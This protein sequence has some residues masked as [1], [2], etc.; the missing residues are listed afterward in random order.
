MEEGINWWPTPA[1]S[2]DMN[3]IER[4]WREL[5]FFL[6]GHVKPLL[7]RELVQGIALFWKL[8]MTKQKCACYI[9]HIQNVLPKEFL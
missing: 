1:S 4:V 6:A 7:K 3:P 8:R 9:S 5:N 2:P